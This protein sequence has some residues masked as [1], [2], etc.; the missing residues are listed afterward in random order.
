MCIRDSGPSGLKDWIDEHNLGICFFSPI[1]HGLLTGKYT[2]P[3]KFGAGD[4]RT[5]VNDFTKIDVIEKMQENKRLLE[6]RF[7]DHSH[8]VMRGIVGA[9]FT[10]A[11]SGCVLLGQRNV[12]QVNIASI[13]G[14]ALSDNDANWVK[15]LYRS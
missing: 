4:F 15:K 8:P 13:L 5:N 12:E 6:Q 7:S 1:K 2:E 11:P 3:V 10:D 9:L 14:E